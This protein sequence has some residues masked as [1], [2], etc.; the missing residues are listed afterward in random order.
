MNDKRKKYITI[1]LAALGLIYFAPRLL[2]VYQ[3]HQV[4][5][6]H[7]SAKPSP[8][9]PMQPST[10]PAAPPAIPF[11]IAMGRYAGDS[12]D[13][14]RQCR[15]NL[16]IRPQ[17]QSYLGYVTM[18][19]FNPFPALKKGPPSLAT[20]P[21]MQTMR[22]MTPA[23]A[24]MTGAVRNGDLVF[25][26]DKSIGTLS[27]GCALTGTFTVSTFGLGKVAAQW[28]EGTCEGGD[29]ILQHI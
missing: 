16:E 2:W 22:Q 17:G 11:V 23:S 18:V 21:I 6:Q 10:S 26:V 1:G 29:L 15:I 7:P 4:A 8:A 14:T 9:I 28:Q 13:K 5:G 25:T 12:F 24:I 19:C 3:Q 27:D 20:S